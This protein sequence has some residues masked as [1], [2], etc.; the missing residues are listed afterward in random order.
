LKWALKVADEFSVGVSV[1]PAWGAHSRPRYQGAALI[2]LATWEA[3][4]N[5]SLH[6]NVGRDFLH[7]DE[8]DIRYG[9]AVEWTLLKAWS[10]LAERY[11]DRGAHFARAGVRW[12]AGAHWSIDLS[13]SFHI[14]GPGASAWTLGATFRFD[15]K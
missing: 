4:D 9:V 8:D 13:R 15:R 3:R 12:F 2:G 11:Q 5:L 10:L 7:R 1:L 6:L 14:S